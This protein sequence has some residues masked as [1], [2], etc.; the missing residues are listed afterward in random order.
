MRITDNRKNMSRLKK[1][2]LNARVNVFFFFL[3]LITAFFSRRIFLNSLGADFLG[4]TGTMESILGFL[5]LA[6]L[7][8][9]VA[10]SY[11]LY[12]PI[13]EN[14]RNEINEIVSVLGFLYR[15]I[16]Q[17]VGGIGLIAG[18]CIPLIFRNAPFPSGILYFS[19]LS[20][21]TSSLLAYFINYHIV[22]LNADQRNYVITAY[23]QTSNIVKLC[24]Q[25]AIAYYTKNY[26]LWILMEMIYGITYSIII[27]RKIYKIYPWLQTD[28]SRGGKMLKNYPGIIVRIKQIFVHK[29]GEFVLKQTDQLI[30][31]AFVSLKMVAFYGNYT[32]IVSKVFL[33][34]NN[35]MGNTGAGVGNLIAEGNKKSIRNIFWELMALRYIMAFVVCFSLYHLL[36]PFIALWVGREYILD[37]TILVFFILNAFILCT[38]WTVDVFIAGFGLFKDTWAPC[39]EAGINLLLS[40]LLA[41]RWGIA[42]VLAG[43]TVSSFLIVYI[44]KPYFLYREGMKSPLG[45]YWISVVKYTGIGIPA[46]FISTK[47]IENFFF[48]DPCKDYAH[49]LLFALIVS[50]T[51]FCT[52]YL[53]MLAC[54][55]GARNLTSRMKTEI[56]GSIRSK[57]KSRDF[58]FRKRN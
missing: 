6:E 49:W 48:V 47:F 54:S 40:V 24:L 37:K 7:G 21:L 27:R 51:I 5:N 15:R 45:E 16:G 20:L 10:V 46:W 33:F 31:F 2:M 9:G 34:L 3:M 14:K 13:F 22:L 32:L 12:K 23:F 1:S 36:E 57:F 19:Y 55:K 53:L 8:I 52:Y 28:A 17:I 56:I 58:K 29:I 26:Y 4:L 41:R 44:W 30:I 11:T 39:T 42:G 43:T 38:R 18:I 25:T 35:L 50:G